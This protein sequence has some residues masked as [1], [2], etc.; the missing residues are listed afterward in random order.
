MEDALRI[1]QGKAFVIWAYDSCGNLDVSMLATKF[2]V[3][4]DIEYYQIFDNIIIKKTSQG[5]I[6]GPLS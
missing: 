4:I 5:Q 1:D 3:I 6:T 2:D